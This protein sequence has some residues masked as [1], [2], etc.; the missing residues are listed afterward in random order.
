MT[1]VDRTVATRVRTGLGALV[2][3]ALVG[4]GLTTSTAAADVTKPKVSVDKGSPTALKVDWTSVK[5]AAAYRVQYST[6]DSF[7]SGTTTVPA[8]NAAPITGSDTTLTGLSTGKTYYV[9]V[10]EVSSDGKVGTYSAATQATPSYPYA[11]PGDLFRSKVDRDSMTVS[12]KAISGAPGYTVRV[13]STGNPTKYF[14]T[15]T[16]SANLTGLKASTTYSIRAYVVKPAAGT[17][18]ETRLSGDSLEVTQATTSYKLATPDGFEETSQSSSSV[19]LS[20]DAVTGAPAGSGY[21]ISYALDGAQTVQRKTTGTIKG[22]SGTISGL[23]S[24]T[25]YYATIYLVDSGGTKISASSDFIVAKSI[26]P[27]GTISGK[28]DGVSGSDLT[29]AAYTTSGDVAKAVTVGSD[30]KYTLDVRPGSY[31]VQLMYTGGGNYASAWARSG[32]DG[33]WTYGTASTIQVALGKTTSVPDV[34]I[35][36]G[37]VVDGKTVDRNGTAVRDVDLTAIAARGTE[38]DVISLTRSGSDGSFSLQG[39]NTGTYWIR[40]AYSGDGFRIESVNLNVDKDLG[41][42]V[43]MDT[44]PFRKKYGAG[45]HGTPKVGKTMSV[46]ATPWLAGTYPTTYASMSYQWKRNGSAIKGAT[47]RTYKL[48]SADRGKKVSVTVTARRYGY[49]TGSVTTSAKRVS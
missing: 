39:L 19:G 1:S 26:V 25:T 47:K 37:H 45:L 20:W 18:P 2:V 24:D 23:N 33:G 38:R 16:P 44:L 11:A 41:V 10:A 8:K 28:V 35:H 42:R 15:T 21:K 7:G 14:T 12:W 34:Q 30:N 46:S 40:A 48:V 31:K 13:D 43:T 22:T 32:S 29:A 4:T 6:S 9:R 17:A 5:G 27:R 3:I 36:K 49:T